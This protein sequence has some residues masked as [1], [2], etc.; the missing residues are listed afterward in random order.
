M[1]GGNVVQWLGAQTLPRL[2]GFVSELCCLHVFGY[3]FPLC[4]RFLTYKKKIILIHIT[5]DFCRDLMREQGR[6]KENV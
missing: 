2:P 1:I 6:E 5:K 3:V 4:I